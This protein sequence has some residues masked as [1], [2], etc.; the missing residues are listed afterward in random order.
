[1]KQGAIHP[2]I[3]FMDFDTNH[4]IVILRQLN[5]YECSLF[6]KEAEL[7]VLYYVFWTSRHYIILVVNDIIMEELLEGQAT[8]FKA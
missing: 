7:L 4:D 3:F 5:L 1:M 6:I 2:L 8:F